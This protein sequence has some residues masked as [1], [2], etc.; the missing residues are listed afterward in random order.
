MNRA[1]KRHQKNLARKA[2]KRKRGHPPQSP[3]QAGSGVPAD[4]LLGLAQKGLQLHQAGQLQEAETVYR[5]ILD[6]K[7][8]FVDAYFNIGT[9]RQAQNRMA[10]ARRHFERVI[11]L[12]PGHSLARERLQQIRSVL[13]DAFLNGRRPRRSRGRR[14]WQ[15]PGCR[16]C[17]CRRCQRE[18]SGRV[19]S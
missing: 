16:R 4:K 12:Q 10:D 1:K 14:Y 3:G 19:G 11:E 17:L 18:E 5:Q 9:A 6:I 7:P 15:R 13:P 8:D 2:L